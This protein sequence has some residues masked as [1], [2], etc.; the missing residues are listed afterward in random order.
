[1]SWTKIASPLAGQVIGSVTDAFVIA[2]WRDPG[3]PPGPP[4]LIAPPY[5]RNTTLN[6]STHNWNRRSARHKP[7]P[8]CFSALRITQAIYDSYAL[9]RHFRSTTKDILSSLR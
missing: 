2:E 8:R 1:M 6:S 9:S 3:G 7:R 4:R 5:P